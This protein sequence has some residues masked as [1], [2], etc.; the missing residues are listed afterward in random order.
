ML[1][2]ILA[3]TPI[4]VF[5][6]LA[7][8]LWLGARQTRPNSAPL[9]RVLALPLAMVLLAGWGVVAAFGHGALGLAGLAAW[10]TS[11]TAVG[12]AV[13][14]QPL[15]AALHYDATSGRVHRPG[16]WTPLLLILTIFALKYCLSVMLVLH[17]TLSRHAPVVAG[18]SLLYGLL[19]GLFAGR[20]LQVWR[21]AQAASRPL[22]AGVR[23]S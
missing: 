16:S 6:L 17:P 13:L 5:A 4:W 21:L 9:W 7:A 2:S 22:A 14:R 15:P 3:H 8:L 11:A 20:A 1:L 19:S 23:G 18:L 12:W 10:A